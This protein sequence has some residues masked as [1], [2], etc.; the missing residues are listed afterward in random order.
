MIKQDFIQIYLLVEDV[1]L[2]AKVRPLTLLLVKID[3]VPNV[4]R[5]S[6]VL[7][8]LVSEMHKVIIAV[9]VWIMSIFVRMS[10][11]PFWR[12]RLAGG[13]GSHVLLVDC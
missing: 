2:V 7:R 5:Q 4:F 3:G 1:Q 6:P 10:R 9:V 13:V 11:C 12:L 8:V